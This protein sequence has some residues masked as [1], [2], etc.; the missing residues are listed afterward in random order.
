VNTVNHT[1][2]GKI[3]GSAF[4]ATLFGYGT[5][6]FNHIVCVVQDSNFTT[7][8]ALDV[9]ANKPSVSGSITVTLADT[10]SYTLCGA[11]E[12]KLKN[13]T[14]GDVPTTCQSG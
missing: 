6:V 2:T 13:G 11:A 3:S 14:T 1:V 9:Q 7:S 10:T 4:P 12:Y 5:V 8:G